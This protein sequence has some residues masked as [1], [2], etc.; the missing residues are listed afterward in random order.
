M[1]IKQGVT[2]LIKQG[3]RQ[4][5]LSIRRWSPVHD[6]TD[7]LVAKM[8]DLRITTLIDV[9]ANLGQFALSARDAGFAGDIYSV[10]PLSTAH[11]ACLAASARDPKWHVLPRMALGAERGTATINVAHNLASSSLLEVDARSVEAEPQSGFMGTEEIEIRSLDD[12]AEA[13]WG[14][15]IALK[16]DTQGFELEVLKGA[17]ASLARVSLILLEM[18]LTPLYEGAPDF[19]TLYRAVEERG[20]RCVGLIQGF[21]DARR[22]ELLQVDGLFERI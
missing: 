19:C 14:D 3:L 11:A 10:E 15:R 1:T 18:S 21:A 13:Q 16:I 8:T 2:G 4:F 9:G 22:N 17:Q 12:V 6:A 7:Q 5:G 20:F